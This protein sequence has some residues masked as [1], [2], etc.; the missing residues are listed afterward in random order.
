MSHPKI[1]ELLECHPMTVVM[2]DDT[3][4]VLRQLDS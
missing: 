1:T 4:L 2:H 3:I